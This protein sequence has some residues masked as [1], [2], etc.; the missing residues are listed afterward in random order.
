MSSSI[1]LSSPATKEFWEIPILFEDE[2]ILALDKPSHLLVSPDRYDP[3]RP[4]LM[5]LLH[6]DIKRGAAWVRNLGSSYLANAHRL[7]FETSGVIMLAKSKPVLIKLAD[8]F[9]IEKP[10]KIH[11][12]LVHGAPPEDEFEAGFKLAPHPTKPGL[13]RIDQEFGKKANSRFCV[14]ERFSRYSLLQ[15]QLCTDRTHQIRLHLQRLK[16]PVVGDAHYGGHPLLLSSLKPNYRFKGDEPEKPL[17]G[18]VALHAISLEI[19]HPVTGASIRVES[20]WPKDLTVAVKYLRRYAMIGG[21]FTPRETD[22]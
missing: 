20:P 18:R 4:N 1:K 13:M 8:Q 21:G 9:G 15:C 10:S 17:I 12:A 6:R 11:V 3:T 2:H 14:T 5:G 19:S 22:A 16:F 7:D